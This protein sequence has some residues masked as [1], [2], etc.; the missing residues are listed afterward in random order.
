MPREGTLVRK[1]C[2]VNVNFGGRKN[3]KLWDRVQLAAACESARPAGCQD[4]TLH[5]F[6]LEADVCRQKDRVSHSRLGQPAAQT[7][8]GP[9]TGAW[10]EAC[11]LLFLT[12]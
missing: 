12:L 5:L 11:L 7:P 10:R 8:S 3:V 4:T 9:V 6:L 2:L 1:C